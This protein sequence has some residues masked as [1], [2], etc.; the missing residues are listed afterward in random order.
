M[1]ACQLSLDGHTARARAAEPTLPLRPYQREAL[2]AIDQRELLGVTRQLVVL[3][4]GAG[5]TIV[6]AHLIAQRQQR[7]ATTG[8]GSGRALFLAHRDELITQ[9]VDKL[10]QVAPALEVGVVKAERDETGADVVVGSVQTLARPSRLA[11]LESDFDLIVA[12]ESHHAVSATWLG[13]LSELG[14]M[15]DDGR[16]P[17]LVGI[18]A[19]PERSDRVGLGQVWQ[20]I[21]YSR[22][23][24]EMI[25]D[26]YLVDARGLLVSTPADLARLRVSHGDLVDAEIGAELVR[27]G[28][29]GS[30][31]EAYATH[32]RDRKGV[33][34]TP[35]VET[36]YSLAEALRAEGIPA[37]G[38]DGTMPREQRRAVLHRL[39]T[40]ETRVV[41]CAQLLSEGW[42]EPSI[43]CVLIAR[44]TRS[45]PAYIQ[46][47]G[48]GL[49]IYPGKT[50]CLILDVVGTTA[51][52]DLMTVADLAGLSKKEVEGH[53]IAE[54]V[55]AKQ[56][57]EAAERQQTEALKVAT[58]TAAASLFRSKLRWIQAGGC[59]VLSVDGGM[60]R[61]EP[62]ATGE[63][64]R[65][66]RDLR[67]DR[68]VVAEGLSLEYAQG[69]GEDQVRQLGASTLASADAPWRERPPTDKQRAFLHRNRVAIP[70]GA[71]R[72]W[73][74]DKITALIAQQ[75]NRPRSGGRR[76]R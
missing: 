9:T 58:E 71:T 2:E 19:T 44:P 75:P 76:R 18:T 14:A 54:A 31:A 74:A 67:N 21:V 63:T 24:L 55:A 17:L 27:S 32:A 4:T 26:G 36:A 6:A 29:L 61:L 3:P 60:I 16:G 47:A 53:T 34:F 23:I 42:D 68:R 66:R 37:E 5:K 41:A 13:V 7:A 28:A 48:R 65:V 64:W 22:S 52:L 46:M 11:R 20:E 39:H 10:H 25:T 38:A 73:A 69:L 43:S 35:T 49:R 40:G 51:R 72:G 45:R 15:R 50:D 56:A 30:I 33:A 1:S 59:F 57:Q 70:D 8:Q 12:D 62:E